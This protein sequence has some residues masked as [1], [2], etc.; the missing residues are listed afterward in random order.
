MRTRACAIAAA[1][2][3]VTFVGGS[4]GAAAA[5]PAAAASAAHATSLTTGIPCSVGGIS[6]TCTLRID[7]FDLVGRTLQA[8]GTV[9]SADGTTTVPFSAP[10]L[11]PASCQIL[12]LTL[13]P[14]HLDLLGLVVDL[15]QVVLNVT[16]QPGP[17]NLLGNL[18]CAVAGLLNNTGGATNAITT[19]LN[20][21][22]GILGGLQV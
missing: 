22:N 11:D 4:A 1:L 19:L 13:G 12:S 20:L 21:I 7:R 8:A 6:Q 15:N 10:V 18:L 16:A 5:S 9:T 3:L 17:G 14:L 2:G